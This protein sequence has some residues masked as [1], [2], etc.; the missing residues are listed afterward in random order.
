MA[1]L[2]PL[3]FVGN[4]V[5]FGHGRLVRSLASVVSASSKEKILRLFIL[6]ACLASA[7]PRF[8]KIF[9]PQATCLA[10][11][12]FCFFC[13]QLRACEAE[14]SKNHLAILRLNFLRSNLK[15]NL[16]SNFTHRDTNLENVK[17][18]S[19][20]FDAALLSC[21]GGRGLN[22]EVAPFPLDNPHPL[23]RF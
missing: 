20:R 6:V 4:S 12:Q 1:C 7:F 13:L 8:R 2:F 11:A 15:S 14:N 19:A 21:Q 16:A 17:F 9:A 18:D 5:S 22:C 10:H 3:Y 23:R